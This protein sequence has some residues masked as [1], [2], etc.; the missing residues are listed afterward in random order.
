MITVWQLQH[1]WIFSF[2]VHLKHQWVLF[3]LS[4]IFSFQ[5]RST[6][7][8]YIIFFLHLKHQIFISTYFEA[9]FSFN[10]WGTIFFFFNISSTRLLLV[11][12]IRSTFL[13]L[14]WHMKH[15]MFYL[16]FEASISFHLTFHTPFTTQGLY[17][18]KHWHGWST[19]WP[20][21]YHPWNCNESGSPLIKPYRITQRITQRTFVNIIEHFTEDANY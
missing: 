9:P 21:N 12:V 6:M 19:A 1:Q 10:I 13:L 18:L 17:T 16:T 11:V 2:F 8:I 15:P 3:C 5:F 7:R 20:L 4:F 14:L